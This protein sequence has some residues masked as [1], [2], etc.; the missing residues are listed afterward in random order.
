M[1]E[2]IK[3]IL[4]RIEEIR[5]R[6]YPKYANTNFK[7]ILE[8]KEKESLKNNKFD[9]IIKEK[10]LKYQIDP[11]L[12]KSI[13]KIE[14]NF[15]PK[16]V[17]PKGAMGLMQLIE[18]TAKEMGVKDVFNPKENIEGGIK[19]LKYLLEEFDQNLPLALAAYNAG[20]ERV[21]R[22]RGIPNIKETKEYVLKVLDLYKKIRD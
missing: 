6:F 10:S 4:G 5:N 7:E 3:N 20:P 18:S 2:G 13:I 21:K 14:S 19:Y 9:H 1:I 16:A 8:D 11:K 17:S 22:D 15:N 12:I